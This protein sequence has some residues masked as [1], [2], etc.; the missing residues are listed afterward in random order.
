VRRGF[1]LIE[2][3]IVVAMILIVAAIVV[4]NVSGNKTVNDNGTIAPDVPHQ[5]GPANPLKPIRDSG[6]IEK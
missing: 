3:M 2:L 4:Q 6:K 5:T 1:T